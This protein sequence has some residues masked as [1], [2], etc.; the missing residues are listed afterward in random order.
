LNTLSLQ[1]AEAVADVMAAAAA[2][3]VDS[4]LEPDFQ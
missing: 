2:V 1:A 3:Q 4:V